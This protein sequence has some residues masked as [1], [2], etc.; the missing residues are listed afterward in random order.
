[1]GVLDQSTW[2]QWVP[3]HLRGPLKDLLGMGEVAFEGTENLL[4]AIQR[5]PAGVNKSIGDA[6]VGGIQSV[7]SD[8]VDAAKNAYNNAVGTFDRAINNTVDDYLGRLGVSSDNAKPEDLKK[9]RKMRHT[10]LLSVF[11]TAIPGSKSLKAGAKAV[12]SSIPK[13]R[14]LGSQA[15]SS[16]MIG[17]TLQS[18]SGYKGA[19]GKP[20][21]VAMPGG[22]KFEARPISQIEKAAK[23]YMQSRGMD[24]SG[25]S[26]YPE[27]SEERA[28]GPV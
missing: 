5:D 18:P 9:A 19:S 28:N 4:G 13:N 15:A 14:N 25:F 3:P 20:S 2:E 6:I 23:S 11:A 22:E 1:M 16:Y 8:P 24:V 12:A 7:A 27:F 21:E 26:K 17:Q 10:D